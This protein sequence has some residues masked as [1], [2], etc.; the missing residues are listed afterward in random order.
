MCYHIQ[1]YLLLYICYCWRWQVSSILGRMKTLRNQ[2]QHQNW[3]KWKWLKNIQWMHLFPMIS[4]KMEMRLMSMMYSSVFSFWKIVRSIFQKHI[5]QHHFV[6]INSCL[7][8]HIFFSFSPSSFLFFLFSK[9]VFRW[10]DKGKNTSPSQKSIDF[11]LFFRKIEGKDVLHKV[12]KVLFPF[13]LSSKKRKNGGFEKIR[14]KEENPFLFFHWICF[15]KEKKERV[16]SNFCLENKFFSFFPFF[17]YRKVK[18]HLFFLSI[19]MFGQKITTNNFSTSLTSDNK[20]FFTKSLILPIFG[21][22]TTLIKTKWEKRKKENWEKRKDK[23]EFLV[24]LEHHVAKAITHFSKNWR[25]C[26]RPI[27]YFFRPLFDFFP[28]V[29]HSMRIIPGS[30]LGFIFIPISSTNRTYHYP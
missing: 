25:H 28:D 3:L 23:I 11:F 24:G 16:E 4:E 2:N 17:V 13:L 7:Q 20:G 22:S 12:R 21:F 8:K 5:F 10:N 9:C 18:K 1:H 30:F 14:R 6:Q 29:E 19:S 27:L 15:W 26:F